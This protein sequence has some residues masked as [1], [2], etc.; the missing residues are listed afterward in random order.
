MMNFYLLVKTLHILSSTILF[1]IG[2]AFFMLRSTFS[3]DLQQRYYAGRNRAAVIG[4]LAAMAGRIQPNGFLADRHIRPFYSCRML[5]VA[6][7]LDSTTTQ[8]HAAGIPD[9]RLAITGPL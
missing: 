7:H 6:G 3:K 1:G 2:I 8:K 4:Y 9:N 5:L